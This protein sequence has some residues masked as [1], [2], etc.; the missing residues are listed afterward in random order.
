MKKFYF[1][2]KNYDAAGFTIKQ[3]LSDR[4]DLELSEKAQKLY[5]ETDP[6]EIYEVTNDETG[7]TEY[8]IDG[9]L[10][11]RKDMTAEDVN[12]MLEQYYDELN[13]EE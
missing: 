7:K 4:T 11:V 3:Y 2:G 12:D 5:D 1:D 13:F 9:C 10:G 6:I 8:W